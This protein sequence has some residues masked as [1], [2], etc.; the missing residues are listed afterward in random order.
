LWRSEDVAFGFASGAQRVLPQVSACFN[1]ANPARLK[2]ETRSVSEGSI[3]GDSS[4]PL[5]HKEVQFT[6]RN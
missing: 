3:L 4:E 2:K 5:M 6:L 1:H